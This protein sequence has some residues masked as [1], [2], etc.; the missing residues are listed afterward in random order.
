MSIRLYENGHI[1]PVRA[2]LFPLGISNAHTGEACLE[3]LQQ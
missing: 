1:L 3:G 2:R